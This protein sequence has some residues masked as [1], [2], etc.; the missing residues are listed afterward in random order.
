MATAGTATPREG[1]EIVPVDLGD[2]LEVEAPPIPAPTPITAREMATA[3]PTRRGIR[4][5]I[6]VLASSPRRTMRGLA[7]TSRLRVTFLRLT[8]RP[9]EDLGRDSQELTDMVGE[10]L[11][12][13]Q[14]PPF[15]RT[16]VGRLT[17]G[18]QLGSVPHTNRYIP[19]PPLCPRC[20]QHLARL[21][22][23]AFVGGHAIV[24]PDEL[25]GI[26]QI[27]LQEFARSHR[28]EVA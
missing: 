6:I 5:N 13:C 18:D 3:T 20:A 11:V 4:G 21:Y 24:R 2:G 17:G 26:C 27:R 7:L 10:T 19:H 28:R 15:G 9:T 14:C 8:V 1:D 23:S 22:L 25:C 16:Q 12:V